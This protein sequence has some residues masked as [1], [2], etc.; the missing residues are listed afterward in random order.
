MYK[1]NSKW[2]SSEASCDQLVLRRRLAIMKAPPSI[3][4]PLNRGKGRS[5]ARRSLALG[6]NDMERQDAPSCE[7]NGGGTPQP[8]VLAAFAPD[9]KSANDL[10]CIIAQWRIVALEA[11]P[12]AGSD[13]APDFAHAGL[14]LQCLVEE[15]VL[16]LI[17]EE[18]E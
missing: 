5:F 17:H 4:L 10:A 18:R 8:R 9:A 6:P 14:T 2:G 7:Q 3:S 12:G 1:G 15:L 11:I 16:S 13:R